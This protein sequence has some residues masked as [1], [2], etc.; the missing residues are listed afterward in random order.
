MARDRT[1]SLHFSLL[2]GSWVLKSRVI[3]ALNGVIAQV[4][5]LKI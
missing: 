2:G 3:S 4:T 1:S 5:I